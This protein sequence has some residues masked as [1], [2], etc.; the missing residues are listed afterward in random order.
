M[1][2]GSGAGPAAQDILVAHELAVV[3]TKCARRRTITR[4]GGIRAPRPFPNVTKHLANLSI[5][6]CRCSRMKLL[7]LDEIAFDRT[8]KRN[9]FPFKFRRQP[10]AAPI[11][12]SVGFEIADMCY[13][14]CFI[15]GTKTGKCELPPRTVAFFPVKRCLPALFVHRHPTERQPKL[16]ARISVGLDKFEILAIC[17]ESRSKRKRTDQHS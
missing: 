15:N 12:E 7:V 16:R 1:S 5:L 4:V 9:T 6:S 8:I 11:C 17:S 2:T 10:R 3:F 13:W 14:L